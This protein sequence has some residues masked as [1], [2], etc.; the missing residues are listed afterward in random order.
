M[1]YDLLAVFASRDAYERYSRFVK[2]SALSKEAFTIFSS[3]G[4]WY[5]SHHEPELNWAGFSAWFLMVRHAK[6]PQEQA[7][8]YKALL[9]MLANR[10]P[11]GDMEA[12]MEGL[13]KRDFAARI[14]DLTLRMADGD[15]GS[16]M[17]DVAELVDQYKESVGKLDALER[18][19]GSFDATTLSAVTT[20][21]INWRLQ[22]LRDSLGP[23]RKGDLI[24]FGKRPDTGGTT[25]LASESTHMA[26]QLDAQLGECVLWI[27]NEEA[28]DKVRR[29]IVQA[30]IGWTVPEMDADMAGAMAEYVATVGHPDAIRV[31]DR[32]KV[33]IKDVETLCK[34]YNPKLIVID[35]LRKMHGFES[36]AEHE[37]QTL[38]F[39]WARELAKAYAPIIVVHQAGAEAEDQKWIPMSALYGA[40]TGPQGEADAIIMMGRKLSDGDTRYIY[41]PKNKLQT[42]GNPAL[43]NGRHIVT[44]RPD[45]AGWEE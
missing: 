8:T 14:A 43:R 4:E 19:L 45:I 33:H 1:D 17:D 26:E 32:A 29:R 15:A 21:G 37:R 30:A 35:Q 28:G 7:E 44:I 22:A 25:F 36:E 2:K 3:M 40:K 20:G 24:V 27:N 34:R 10:E 38:L 5:K 16:T 31:F 23:I 42:P 18:D 11:E 9:D 6:L 13:M 41:V 39:N 12:L